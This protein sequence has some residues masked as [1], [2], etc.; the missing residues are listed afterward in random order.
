MIVTNA[1]IKSDI[2][3]KSLFITNKSN[4]IS[5]NLCFTMTRNKTFNVTLFTMIEKAQFSARKHAQ[6][7]KTRAIKKTSSST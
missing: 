1:H 7:G 5:A 2:K 3:T 4:N 6:I